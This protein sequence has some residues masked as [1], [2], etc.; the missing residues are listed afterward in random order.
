[1]RIVGAFCMLLSAIV[2]G[3]HVRVQAAVKDA[4]REVQQELDAIAA[5]F[6]LMFSG[7]AKI[8]IKTDSD[9]FKQK[10][11]FLGPYAKMPNGD[12]EQR[13]ICETAGT[14]PSVQDAVQRLTIEGG[15]IVVYAIYRSRDGSTE[16]YGPSA[17]ERRA[18]AIVFRET[19]ESWPGAWEATEFFLRADGS[20]GSLR[21]WKDQPTLNDDWVEVDADSAMPQ[22][23]RGQAGEATVRVGNLQIHSIEL[24]PF[25]G[26]VYVPAA[27]A[28]PSPA[29]A[30]P[31][32]DPFAE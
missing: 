21:R 32:D 6:N 12:W 30:P 28:E 2:S 14:N 4:P 29:A 19:G 7:R 15:K 31:V 3:L 24:D 13:N 25:N 10:Q 23:V 16:T 17:V 27:P 18:S 1:M 22:A 5:D 8:T 11:T 20:L 26:D 9:R